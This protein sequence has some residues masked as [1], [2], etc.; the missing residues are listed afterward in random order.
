MGRPVRMVG[1]RGPVL[2]HCGQTRGQI[3]FSNVQ[4][5]YSFEQYIYLRIYNIFSSY[6]IYY[7]IQFYLYFT[8]IS[9]AT[10]YGLY[11]CTVPNIYLDVFQYLIP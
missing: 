5:N 9:I 2:S 8:Y 10:G 1:G 6:S 3:L 11:K 4:Q 7:Y